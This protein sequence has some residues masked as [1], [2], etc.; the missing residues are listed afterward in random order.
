MNLPSDRAHHGS[1]ILW[2]SLIRTHGRNVLI[3]ALALAILVAG[4]GAAYVRWRQGRQMVASLEF[5]PTFTGMEELTYP[6]K[7]P[8][9]SNDITV[10]SIIDSV[11]DNND[12][13]TVCDR[14]SFRGGFFVEQRSDQSTFLDLEYQSRLSEPRI[15]IV[16]RKLLQEE[17]A[18]KR[19]ALPLQYRLNF[20]T[21]KACSGLRQVVLSKVMVDVLKTWA[22]ESET[23]RGVLN[24]QVQVLT[25]AT[26]DVRSVGAGGLL[27][28]ADLLRIAIGRVIDNIAEVAKIPGA[29]LIRLGPSRVT[30]M[31]VQGKLVDLVG[32]RLDPLV[33]TSG[34]S[35]VRESP[36]W[37]NETVEVAVRKQHA[38]ERKAA[39]Y[40]AALAD[41]SSSQGATGPGRAASVAAGAANGTNSQAMMA[42]V[43][44]SF[45]DRIVE[46]S[47]ASA[48]Y[49]QQLTDRMVEAELEAVNE[50]QRASYYR[51]LLQASREQGAP[52]G[53][54][55]QLALS[56]NAI[57][58]EGKILTKQ[59]GELYDEFSKVALRSSAAL[60]VTEK[61]VTIETTQTYSIQSVLKLAAAT[62]VAT[63][64]LAFAFLLLRDRWDLV[65]R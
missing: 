24:Y 38:A 64:L 43:D 5:R 18:A 20:V 35:M 12:I 26:L 49:R 28:R 39:A 62:F 41:F 51:R 21:P 57:V 31:E 48:V 47:A 33:M 37:V 6:N 1:R 2:L 56:L 8:F 13:G 65:V 11:Y 22:A 61:P 29:A 16:E 14:E 36:M 59:F 27:L 44:R 3:G 7:L 45:I 17:H 25:P 52:D 60:Y 55:D 32:S 50:E 40:K 63:L 10:G 34:R 46:M 19:K 4:L 58:E 30:F 23:K 42:Q 53:D 15:T 54:P 9:S